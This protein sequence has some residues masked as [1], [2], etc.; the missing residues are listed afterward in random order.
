MYN[1]AYLFRGT[2][3]EITFSGKFL[4]YRYVMLY[5]CYTVKYNQQH[6]YN[7]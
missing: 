5:I 7:I 3:L 4:E 1:Y 2:E 6:L